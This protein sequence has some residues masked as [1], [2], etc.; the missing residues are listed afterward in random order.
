[1]L[2][3]PNDAYRILTAG[4]VPA[5]L[6]GLPGLADLLGGGPEDWSC[7]D[8]AD[9]NLNAVF[10]V[11]GPAGGLCVKQALPYVR[12]AGESWPMDINRAFFEVS[13]ARRIGAFVS[14]L[15]PTIHH[16]D[17]TK[18]VIVMEKLA[19]HIILRRAMIVGEHYPRVATDVAEYVAAASFF[20]SD[21]A[22]P[23]ETKAADQA[24]FSGNVALQRISVD[25]IFTD[26]YTVAERNR[27][28]APLEGW[29]AAFRADID[30]KEAVARARLA[31]LTHAQSLLHGDLHSGSIMVTPEET[32]VIDGEFAWVG[33]SGFDIGNFIAHYVMAW[34]A[35]P[36]HGAASG[37]TAHFRGL[38]AADILT[39][40]QHFETR[41]LAHWRG[42]MG[43][44]RSFAGCWALPRSPIS[45]RLR[46]SRQGQGRRPAPW[47]S[48]AR[49]CSTRGA[50]A[51]SLPWL[52]PCRVS[53]ARDPT[54]I[55]PARS[56]RAQAAA[57][58]RNRAS[59][60]RAAVTAGPVTTSGAQPAT[61]QCRCEKSG[62]IC[63]T[64]PPFSKALRSACGSRLSAAR[65]STLSTSCWSSS[66]W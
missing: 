8:V 60:A 58:A 26:P 37:E 50:T 64:P 9:G 15:A 10:L 22:N 11:D 2:D 61:S 36:F 1:M 21:L 39:F 28:T 59:V 44:A 34:Y 57:W 54:R 19:P 46:M 63:M 25:L 7:R 47:P 49:R 31:Y 5:Y 23:F 55:G 13:Y 42:F 32:R 38:L 24:L 56:E 48:H 35:T 43:A 41:F 33:P 3:Q 62:W 16:F 53:R 6:A 29:A 17:Q 20:T 4:D 14:R 52:P 30:L 40:W 66:T 18:F 12:V 27:V 65:P 51:I 45:W